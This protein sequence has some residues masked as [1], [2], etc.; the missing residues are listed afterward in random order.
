MSFMLYENKDR[1]ELILCRNEISLYGILNVYTTK[2]SASFLHSLQTI[3]SVI[4]N[5]PSTNIYLCC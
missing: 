4:Y 2:V 3:L 1:Y 5:I